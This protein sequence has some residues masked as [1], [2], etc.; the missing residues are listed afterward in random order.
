MLTF[1]GWL[2]ALLGLWVLEIAGWMT[3]QREMLFGAAIGFLLLTVDRVAV[4]V[5]S[6]RAVK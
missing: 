5:R 6:R 3:G 1:K 4:L 2:G